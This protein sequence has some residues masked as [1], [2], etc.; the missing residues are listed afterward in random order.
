MHAKVY[1]S[2][3]FKQSKILLLQTRTQS[4]FKCFWGERRLGIGLRRTRGLMGREEGNIA[5]P[6]PP[7]PGKSALGTRLAFSNSKKMVTILHR[8]TRA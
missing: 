1:V 7:K 4:L 5:T 2:G 8:V 3:Y 6:H